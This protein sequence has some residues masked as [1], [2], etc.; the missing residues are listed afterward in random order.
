MP[1]V[2]LLYQSEGGFLLQRDLESLDFEVEAVPS[3]DAGVA[4][5]RSG[6]D[7]V[8]LEAAASAD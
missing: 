8:V 7:V 6:F 4:M 5:T 1:K 2:L 3:H